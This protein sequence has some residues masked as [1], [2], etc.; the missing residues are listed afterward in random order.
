MPGPFVLW[1]RPSRRI[2]ARCHS[3]ATRSERATTAST[4]MTTTSRTICT[5][6]AGVRGSVDSLDDA[7]V[8]LG[9]IAQ[10]DECR[11]VAGAVVR[12]D[13][14]GDAGELDQ[15]GALVDAGLIGLGSAAAGE[16]LAAACGDRRAGQLG[17]L[18]KR[19]GVGDRAVAGDPVCL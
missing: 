1:K 17:V 8:A 12:G 10:R 7:H 6:M 9:G 3:A 4:M 15:D 11:L 13:R 5:V 2:T 19:S 14:L 16:E 18:G